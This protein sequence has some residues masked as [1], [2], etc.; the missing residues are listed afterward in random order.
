MIKRG[1]PQGATTVEHYSMPPAVLI[2]VMDDDNG[3]DRCRSVHIIIITEPFITV[4]RCTPFICNACSCA[5]SGYTMVYNSRFYH[6]ILNRLPAP[7]QPPFICQFSDCERPFNDFVTIAKI[8]KPVPVCLYPRKT[9]KL[10]ICNFRKLSEK[11]GF[12]RFY[13]V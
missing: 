11:N 1:P 12:K 3:N 6:V 9:M 5:S 4:E 13:H 7:L 2:T 10:N 8:P